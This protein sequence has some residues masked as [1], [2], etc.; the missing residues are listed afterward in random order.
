MLVALS[1]VLNYLLPF[2]LYLSALRHLKAGIAAQYL[3]AIPVFGVI[4]SAVILGE[5][6][7]ILRIIGTLIVVLSLYLFATGIGDERATSAVTNTSF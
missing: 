6:M 5:P 2:W 4:G 3:T 7:T 1:G